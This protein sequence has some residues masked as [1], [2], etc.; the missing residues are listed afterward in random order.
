MA[1][2]RGHYSHV[3][4]RHPF[5]EF[6]GGL[7]VWH[8]HC[9]GSG[10]CSGMGAIPGLGI[11][12]CLRSGQKQKQKQKQKKGKKGFYRQKGAG[13]RKLYSLTKWVGFTWQ[14]SRLGEL[15]L[16]LRGL[17]TRHGIREAAGLVPGLTQ[18]V[19]DMLLPPAV[20]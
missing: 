19:E 17:R 1:L 20:A 6:P 8:G 16:W 14:K 9:H 10:C 13:T 18:W 5:L 7:R 12:T 15:L 3:P 11:S 2:E 4:L